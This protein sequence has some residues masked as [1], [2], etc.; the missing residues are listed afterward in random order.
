MPESVKTES[1]KGGPRRKGGPREV[2]TLLL[3]HFDRNR[4]HMP[5]RQTSDPYAIWVSEVM[6][7][8]TRVGAVIP[9]YERW[10]AQF[11]DITT[12][13]DADTEQVLRAWEGL[14]YYS[15]ARNLHAAARIVRERHGG[16]VPADAA[17][18]RTLPGIGAYTAGAVASI[19]YAQRE[20]AVDGNAR[21][22]FSRLLD[23]P[24]PTI[25]QTERIAR[26]YVPADRPG[27]FNQAVME[28]GALICTPANP[29]CIDC[30]VRPHCLAYARGT[31]DERPGKSQRRAVPTF[32]LACVV[33]LIGDSVVLRQR[34]DSGL[35]AGFWEFPS[36]AA[37]RTSASRI[38]RMIAAD[39]VD[40]SPRSSRKRKRLDA[41]THVFSH[42]IETYHPF[43]FQLPATTAL[44]DVDAR[45]CTTAD[46]RALPM[47]VAQR[48]IARA[49]G[50]LHD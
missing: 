2:A 44:C 17:S 43:V 34:P 41:V 48:K 7:Q 40:T 37:T 4:R 16:R 15:R 32:D 39:M 31:V 50:L 24:Q 14:G 10:L 38:A 28:L 46:L 18:L 11:P 23:L 35:L 33:L 13:A 45:L 27:D 36:A 19:A 30:P 8:Q 25:P 20:P 3:A 26:D 42:R 12:L 6:L 5:W 29:R 9:Y 49:A 22:V 47:A 1:P 21:R